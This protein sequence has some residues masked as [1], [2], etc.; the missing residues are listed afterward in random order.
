MQRRKGARVA[1]VYLVGAWVLLQVGGT[2]VGLG[3]FPAWAGKTRLGEE[4]ILQTSPRGIPPV[5]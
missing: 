3:E 5:L 4:A 1:I 2:I